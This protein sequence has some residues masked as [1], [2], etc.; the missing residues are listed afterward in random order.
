VRVQHPLDTLEVSLPLFVF[1]EEIKNIYFDAPDGAIDMSVLAILLFVGTM[2]LSLW[3][4]MRVRQVYGKF[5]Q[6]PASSGASGA[7]TA[8]TILRQE[9]IYDVQIVEHDEILGAFKSSP[10]AY[11]LSWPA[12]S[13][14][15]DQLLSV[16]SPLRLTSFYLSIAIEPRLTVSD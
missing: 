11:N 9:G 14:E 1:V 6:L 7:E 15:L 16:V 8:A 5:S 12:P 4:T 3:A 2:A 10:D 13:F